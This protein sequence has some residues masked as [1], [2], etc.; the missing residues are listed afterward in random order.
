MLR[1]IKKR[2][3]GGRGGGYVL[4]QFSSLCLNLIMF[5]VRHGVNSKVTHEI[6]TLFP[7]NLFFSFSINILTKKGTIFKLQYISYRIYIQSTIF[8]FF[9]S[10]HKAYIFYTISKVDEITLTNSNI[11]MSRSFFFLR[12]VYVNWIL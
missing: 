6:S 8:S 3:R 4:R 10:C 9:L 1:T 11:N 7:C 12:K 5:S 2:T